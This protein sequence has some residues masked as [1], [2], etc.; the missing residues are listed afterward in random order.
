MVLE[1]TT[2]DYDT[3]SIALWEKVLN[4]SAAPTLGIWNIMFCNNYA[5]WMARTHT[6]THILTSKK[7]AS[8]VLL[9]YGYLLEMY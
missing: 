2:D 3:T 8:I 7:L 9:N 1:Y 4:C 5:P 6:D